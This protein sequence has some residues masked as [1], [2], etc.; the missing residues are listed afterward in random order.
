MSLE[1]VLTIIVTR[2]N[3]EEIPACLEGLDRA[4]TGLD[5]ETV[6]IDN[7]SKDRTKAIL[8]SWQGQGAGREVVFNRKNIG[9][10]RAVNMGAAKFDWCEKIVVLNPDVVPHEKSI[11]RLSRA[12][13]RLEHAGLLLPKLV[14]KHGRL[15]PSCRTFYDARTI[16][17][18]RAPVLNRFFASS[19]IVRRHLML[20]RDHD[21]EMEVDWGQGAAFMVRRSALERR[22][23][24]FDPGYFLYFED[25]DLAW[26]MWNRGYKVM[27]VPSSVMTHGYRRSSAGL[28]NISAF[29]HLRSAVRFF[30][31]TRCREPGRE[32]NA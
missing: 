2:N 13:D 18:R 27:Y 25:V 29:L 30:L 32:N 8:S 16:L 28:S 7:A 6:V 11:F 20:D 15:Q 14:D 23:Q 5:L 4:G 3:G 12:M 10:A 26:S 1:R 24:V 22:D 31:K 9:L 21:R 17:A 19:G